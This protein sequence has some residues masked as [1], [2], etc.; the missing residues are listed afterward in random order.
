M[1]D[2]KGDQAAGVTTADLLKGLVC[3]YGLAD[4]PTQLLVKELARRGA[5]QISRVGP[6]GYIQLPVTGPA[7][8]LVVRDD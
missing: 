1:S 4:M 7:T 5:V 8:V 2:Q 3:P 6:S